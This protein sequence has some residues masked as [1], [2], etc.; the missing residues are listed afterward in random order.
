MDGHFNHVSALHGHAC[1]T[2]A[3]ADSPLRYWECARG[4][5]ICGVCSTSCHIKYL[6]KS[7]FSNIQQ[8]VV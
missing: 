5:P 7:D 2:T 1:R 6:Q 8:A 4:D 3:P